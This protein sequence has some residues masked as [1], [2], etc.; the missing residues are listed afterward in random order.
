[1]V[2][3]SK[4]SMTGSIRRESLGL[5]NESFVKKTEG[6]SQK[7]NEDT[8]EIIFSPNFTPTVRRTQIPNNVPRGTNFR[9]SYEFV[10]WFVFISTTTLCVIDGFI[11]SGDAVCGRAS[12]NPGKL[13]DNKVKF[14]LDY[15]T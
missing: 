14:N 11:M 13:W 2:A 3:A 4:D 5:T 7:E 15:F 8:S 6:T 9:L 12:K 10:L 1:M